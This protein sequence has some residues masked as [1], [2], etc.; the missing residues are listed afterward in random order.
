MWPGLGSIASHRLM[1]GFL[2]QEG[3]LDS[4]KEIYQ[5][6]K[7]HPL[8]SQCQ[9]PCHTHKS[10]K[11]C[12][13]KSHSLIVFTKIIDAIIYDYVHPA[14]EYKLFAL[15]KELDHK[16]HSQPQDIGISALKR[17]IVQ[18][19]IQKIV[20]VSN[21]SDQSQATFYYLKQNFPSVCVVQS[22][23]PNVKVP[24][25]SAFNP[26][27]LHRLQENISNLITQLDLNNL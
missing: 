20:F 5:F 8:C 22:G 3:L 24:S 7:Q 26:D 13:K 23:W 11:N 12:E 6:I 1:D 27:E 9:L 19:D 2:S 21:N 25:L 4:L 10:C 15:K 14:C 18:K 17:A 16:I